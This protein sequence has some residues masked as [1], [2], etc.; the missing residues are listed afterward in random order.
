M[1]TP[2][3][4]SMKGMESQ[5][6]QAGN[7]YKN[8]MVGHNVCMSCNLCVLCLIH[9]TPCINSMKGM[10]SIRAKR[11]SVALPSFVRMT[12]GAIA[13]CQSIGLRAPQPCL[14]Y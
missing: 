1:T 8:M 14:H 7:D 12:G 13:G 5:H 3:I 10:E 2:C 6:K 9:A 11:L 4:N